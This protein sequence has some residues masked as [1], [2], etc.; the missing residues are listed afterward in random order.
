MTEVRILEISGIATGFVALIAA[1]LA[2]SGAGIFLGSIHE[3]IALIPGLLLIVPA[4]ISMRGSISGVLVSRLS[5]SM[6]LGAFEVNIGEESVLGEGTR[7]ALINTVVLSTV[8]GLL[9]SLVAQILGLVG[10]GILDFILISVISGVI[11]GVLLLSVTFA[12][13]LA[14]Y[15][16]NLDLDMIGAPAV[17]TAGDIVTIPIIAGTAIAVLD[18]PGT[19]R[20]G[21]AAG[22]LVLFALAAMYAGTNL[23]IGS[24]VAESLALLVPLLIL[25]IVAGTVYNLEVG[26]LTGVAALLILIPPFMG[27]S[28]SIGGILSSRISTGMHMGTIP[29]TILPGRDVLPHITATYLYT[30]I[31]MP[32]VAVIAHFAAE[33][34][35]LPSPGILAL[36]GIALFAGLLL[37][38]LVILLAH[39]IAGLSFSYGLDPDNFGIPIITTVI[40][41]IGAFILIAT[42]TLF[43]A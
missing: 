17:T 29:S 26:L 23:R 37:M 10:L 5:S 6:H 43:I 35:G 30:L 38:T 33:A 1:S 15:R 12:V 40:D 41:L 31:L 25:E 13:S 18:L 9:A 11:S 39:L 42:M 19:Y 22:V 21:L 34:I 4:S 14:S 36:I 20:L 8:L 32:L 2:E 7:V 28:G 27:I 24:V 16:Y 3:L